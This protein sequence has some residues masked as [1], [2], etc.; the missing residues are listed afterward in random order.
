MSVEFKTNP[1]S[2]WSK[3]IPTATEAGPYDIWYRVNGGNNY[4]SYNPSSSLLHGDFTVRI[5]KAAIAG[6]QVTIDS[7]WTYGNDPKT[8][9]LVKST[10]PVD[11]DGEVTFLYAAAAEGEDPDIDSY[12]P[13]V[14]EESGSYAVIAS[15]GATKNYK[16]SYTAPARFTIS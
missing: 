14:P 13:V 3:E 7:S 10:V 5:E 2:A 9:K 8:P 11:Y 4:N 6:A 16:L 12:S 1:L 15:L